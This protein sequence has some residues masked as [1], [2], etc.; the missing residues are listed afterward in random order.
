MDDFINPK[1]FEPYL[2]NWEELTEQQQKEIKEQIIDN[3]V[4][5]LRVA[6]VEYAHYARII[7]EH[8][9]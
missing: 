2:C 4:R 5:M 9:K 1:D 8:Y 7:V 3:Y 6:P